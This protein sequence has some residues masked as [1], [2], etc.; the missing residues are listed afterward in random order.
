MG[1]KTHPYK[2]VAPLL[3]QMRRFQIS[4][5]SVKTWGRNRE[6]DRHRRNAERTSQNIALASL[7]QRLRKEESR[8]QAPGMGQFQPHFKQTLILSL[9]IASEFTILHLHY[10]PEPP[11][12]WGIFHNPKPTGSPP[13]INIQQPLPLQ[14]VQCTCLQR[15]VSG[16][17]LERKQSIS[18]QADNTSSQ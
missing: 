7:D 15:T 14:T 3:F 9:K 1:R 6:I 16:L 5:Q 12:R 8:T 10:P 11:F 4:R 18:K 13:P 17:I 2:Y